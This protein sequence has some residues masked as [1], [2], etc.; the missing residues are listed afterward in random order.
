MGTNS[1]CRDRPEGEVSRR[2]HRLRIALGH[3]ILDHSPLYLVT[4][5]AAFGPPRNSPKLCR[6]SSSRPLHLGN[7]CVANAFVTQMNAPCDGLPSTFASCFF[8]GSLTSVESEQEQRLR[9]EDGETYES[10][11]DQ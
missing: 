11:N 3:F 4:C 7:G 5:F 1:F 9:G 6:K 8:D 2:G 10:V